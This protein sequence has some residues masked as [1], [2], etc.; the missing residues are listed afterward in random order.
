MPRWSPRRRRLPAP[1]A[2]GRRRRPAPAAAGQDEVLGSR[3]R[4]PAG[5]MGAERAGSAGDEH[6]PRG[7]QELAPAV[8]SGPGAWSGAVR[9]SRRTK[10]PPGRSAIWSSP[11][12]SAR[13][14]HRR[15]VS[16]GVP[17]AGVEVSAGMSTSPP[18]RSGCSTATT[19]PSP[20]TAA[21]AGCTVRSSQPFAVSA[22][23][24]A[25][26]VTFHTGASTPASPRACASAS[27]MLRPDGGPAQ[28]H[29]V[30]VSAPASPS[31]S[32]AVPGTGRRERTPLAVPPPAAAISA[33]VRRSRSAMVDRSAVF[34]STRRGWTSAPRRRRPVRQACASALSAWPA[35]TAMIQCPRRTGSPRVVHGRHRSA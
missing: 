10:A 34:G 14:E 12:S 11:V 6:R 16:C 24:T 18:Q 1:P 30:S 2:A 8:P 23:E 3:R 5:D 22:V 28:L 21:C 15:S 26:R 33:A 7:C 9:A 31:A 29:A 35:G 17:H 4:Q 19:R 25:P 20:H 27:V 13:T 32:G